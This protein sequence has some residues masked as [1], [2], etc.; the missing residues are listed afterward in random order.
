MCV[1]NTLSV[2]ILLN[3]TLTFVPAFSHTFK[4]LLMV[5]VLSLQMQQTGYKQNYIQ[6]NDGN[7]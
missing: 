6:G 4:I 1:K 2:C 3:L 7:I 5:L